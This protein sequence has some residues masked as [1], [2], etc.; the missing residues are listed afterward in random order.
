MGE[1]PHRLLDSSLL[2]GPTVGSARSK[3]GLVGLGCLEESERRA[4]F[5]NQGINSRNPPGSSSVSRI[6]TVGGNF[7]MAVS[8]QTAAILH[9]TRI[10]SAMHR[11]RS[12]TEISG[13]G[14]GG[15][16]SPVLEFPE[17]RISDMLIGLR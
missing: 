9:V 12:C 3:A 6:M 15:R 16:I 7:L 11:A 13:S 8:C 14:I 17:Q 5:L 1:I 2:N 4:R 10:T